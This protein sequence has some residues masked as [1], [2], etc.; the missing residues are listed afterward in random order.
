ML[1]L[2]V[3][4]DFTSPSGCIATL[5]TIRWTYQFYSLVYI[6][7]LR[8]TIRSLFDKVHCPVCRADIN[9]PVCVRAHG[10]RALYNQA[11]IRYRET[12]EDRG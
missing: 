9:T 10:A 6:V 7:G 5:L 2:S 8:R 11:A 4:L 3:Q 12:V 1:L